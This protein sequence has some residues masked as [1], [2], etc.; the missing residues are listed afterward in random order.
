LDAVGRL[1]GGIAH[2]F[3][4]LLGVIE[5]YTEFLVKAVGDDTNLRG[6][7]DEIGTAIRS[8]SALISQ[9]LAFSRKQL[10]QPQVL[11]LNFVVSQTVKMLRRIVGEDIIV[12]VNLTPDAGNVSADVGQLQQVIMNLALNACDAMPRGGI[13]TITTENAEI[14]DDNSH[15]SDASRLGNYVK[16]SL[17]DTGVGMDAETQRQAFEPFFTTKPRGQ[18]TGLGLATVYGIVKQ[19]DGYVSLAS[20]LGKGTIAEVYL[21]RVNEQPVTTGHRLSAEIRKGTET[22]LLVED[23][24]ALRKMIRIG[25]ERNG[26]T[27]ISAESGVDALNIAHSYPEPIHLLVTDVIMPEMDG[28]SLAERIAQQRPGIAVLYMSGHT[29]ELLGEHG[30]LSSKVAFIKKPFDVPCLMAKIRQAMELV[31]VENS[32]SNSS[33]A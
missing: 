26:Y 17:G 25:L 28:P 31:T 21:K 23:Y 7:G 13:L 9:L 3:N 29:D 15:E 5:G 12:S 2:D 27:V 4:N 18:G 33:V 10:L 30:V 22:I 32:R 14:N 19:S 11:S 6:I 8:A 1:A 24:L 20:E 16:L